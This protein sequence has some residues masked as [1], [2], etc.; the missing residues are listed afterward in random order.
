METLNNSISLSERL[1]N[2]EEVKCVECKKGYYRP[3]NPK[4]KI[5]HCFVCDKCGSRVTLEPNVV[6]DE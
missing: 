6:V 2:E 5:N 3:I 1:N 4:Y